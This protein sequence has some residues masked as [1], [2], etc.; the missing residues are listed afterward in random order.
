LGERGKEVVF[1]ATS[2]DDIH[3]IL[4]RIDSLL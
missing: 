4:A 2:I 3:D 1:S